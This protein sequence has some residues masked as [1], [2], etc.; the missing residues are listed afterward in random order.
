MTELHMVSWNIRRREALMRML[1]GSVYDATLFQE[2]P[3]PE[4]TWEREYYVRSTTVLRL[5]D[6]VKLL[7]LKSIQ[8]GRRPG[9]DEIAVSAPGTVA[10]RN[11]P[12]WSHTVRNGSR[13][14]TP[15]SGKSVRLL[16]TGTG[17]VDD[18]NRPDRRQTVVGW[19]TAS[20]SSV[21]RSPVVTCDA[22]RSA[23]ITSA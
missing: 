17:E 19:P 7:K 22:R 16:R 12:R 13:S 5:S 10:A 3:L 18:R 6:R 14:S 11:L 4:D 15:L 1:K 8:Q 21:R 9:R 20:A 23:V 2:T